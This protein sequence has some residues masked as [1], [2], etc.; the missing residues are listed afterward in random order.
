M[1]SEHRFEQELPDL[2][3]DLYLGPAPAYRHDIVQR[4]ALTRQRPAWTFPER[5]LPMSAITFARTVFRP[6][7]WRT[8]GLLALL[9]L[10]LVAAV[11]VYM[12]TRPKV[13]SPFGPARN[14]LIVLAEGGD[15]VLVDPV[16]GAR[17]IAVGGTA[18]DRAP[19]FS[20]DG[21]RLAFLRDVDDSTSLWLANADGTNPRELASGLSPVEFEGGPV[22]SRWMEWSPDGRSILLATGDPRRRTVSIVSIDGTPGLR[23]LELDTSATGP[24]WRP[25]DGREILFRAWTPTGWGLFAVRPDGTGQRPVT[26]SNGINEYDGLFFSWSPDGSRVAYQW[27]ETTGP[28]KQRLYVVPADG[29]RP[30]PITEAESVGAQW[31]PDG[32]KIAFWDANSSVPGDVAPVSV[33]RVDGPNERT[34]LSTDG[35][36]SFLWAPDSATIIW[37]PDGSD[38]PQLLDAGGGPARPVS[39]SADALPDWQRLAP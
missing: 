32:T 35:G 34:A 19:A 23:T 8:I 39:W 1:T 6:L 38:K 25:P 3:A 4:A 20:R 33:V 26:P 21:T 30:R 13:P 29:G 12:G 31:S 24:T 16:S 22:R 15:I 17:T 7:P 36:G 28:R 14:G 2:L 27:R 5:W 9:A 18:L 37:L 10:L 11:A